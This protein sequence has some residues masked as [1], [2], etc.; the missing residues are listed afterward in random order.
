MRIPCLHTWYKMK[1]LVLT[2]WLCTGMKSLRVRRLNAGG[3]TAWN[4]TG[5]WC[6]TVRP[7]LVLAYTSHTVDPELVTDLK[8]PCTYMKDSGLLPNT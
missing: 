3:P 8:D 4:P 5:S 1:R 2:L 7:L 6:I